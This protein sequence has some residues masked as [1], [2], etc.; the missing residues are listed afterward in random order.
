M[1][2]HSRGCYSVD[3]AVSKLITVFTVGILVV[4]IFKS[5]PRQALQAKTDCFLRTQVLMLALQQ[6]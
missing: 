2:N 5:P 3:F 4:N 6:F 1:A